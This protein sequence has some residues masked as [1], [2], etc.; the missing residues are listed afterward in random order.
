MKTNIKFL[1]QIQLIKSRFQVKA[2]E[3]DNNCPYFYPNI[4]HQTHEKNIC[5]LFICF[6]HPT[7]PTKKDREQSA[8]CQ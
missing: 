7:C 2:F 6:F 5:F 3:K 4:N 1:G 8:H